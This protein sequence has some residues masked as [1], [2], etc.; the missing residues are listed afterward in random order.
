MAR[1]KNPNAKPKK[2]AS[3]RSYLVVTQEE[4]EQFK[5][6]RATYESKA[7]A[8]EQADRLATEADESQP[9]VQHSFAL[10]EE[11]GILSTEVQKAVKRNFTT[12]RTVV[13]A[14]KAQN[15]S[16]PQEA[17]DTEASVSNDT[18]VASEEPRR[19]RR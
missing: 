15:E 12:A 10:V 19:K 16:E 7:K 17:A 3:G 4:W 6:G 13:R 11:A 5:A 2:E 14:P 18:E 9:G 8:M 1:P